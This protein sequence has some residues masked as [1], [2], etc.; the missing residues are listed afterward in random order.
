MSRGLN[1]PRWIGT[2]VL[3]LAGAVASGC[4]DPSVPGETVAGPYHGAIMSGNEQ[5]GRVAEKVPEPVVLEVRGA[6]GRL[7]PGVTVVWTSVGPEGTAT[8]VDSTV[9]DA[10]GRTSHRWTLGERAGVHELHAAQAVDLTRTELATATA[11]ALPGPPAAGHLESSSVA[12]LVPGDS[13]RPAVVVEDRFGNVASGGEVAWTSSRTTVATFDAGIV[14]AHEEGVATLQSVIGI[15]TLRLDVAVRSPASSTLL[16]VAF[17]SCNRELLPQPL[18]DDILDASPDL[19][20]WLGDNIYGDTEDMSFLASKYALQKANA[21]YTALRERVP[22]VG[23]WDDH[24]YGRNNAGHEYPMRAES[25]QLFLDFFDV[26]ADDPRRGRAGVY[27]SR[28]FGPAGQRVKVIMLDV[29]YHREAP[30][31]TADILGEE[32]WAWLEQEL[33]ESDAQVNLIASGIQIVAQDHRYEKWS[34]FPAA[35]ARLF[36]LIGDSGA[37]G[38]LILSGDRHIG[39]ISRVDGTAAGSPLYDITSSGLTHSWTDAPEEY[40]R[41]RV[42]GIMRDLHYG[43]L[44]FDWDAGTVALQLRDVDNRLAFEEVM[45][46]Q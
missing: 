32:Q 26:P 13:L 44:R 30:G 7:A 43:L 19:W 9:T 29:R 37:R 42:A 34:N 23:T 1:G 38:V 14:R 46:L 5:Q 45:E 10:A 20:V 2:L 17:G 6:G 36:Q 35:R 21:G 16:H 4:G 11:T 31:A 18:W 27:S 40:N 3:A 28:T 15:D 22:V 24:D 12:G 25:Q 33:A 41:H 8:A 39:E